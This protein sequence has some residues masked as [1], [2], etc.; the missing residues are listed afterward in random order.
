MS[1]VEDEAGD[2]ASAEPPAPGLGRSA[3]IQA[4]GTLLSRV[5]GFGRVFALAYALGETRLVDTYLLANNTPNIIYELVLGGVLSGTVL[6]VFV[7]ALRGRDEKEGWRA[8]S[9]VLTLAALA[10]AVLSFAFVVVAPLFIRLYTLR[11]GGELR[12]DQTAV[13]VDLLR[14]F[15]PQ[16]FFYGMIS[17]TSALLRARR[18]FAAPMFAPILNNVIVI[19]VF[20]AYPHLIDGR[21]LADVRGNTTA[22]VLLG[23]GTT[24]GVAAMALAQLPVRMIRRHV[25]PVWQP[26]HP[27]VRRILGL[28]GWTIGFVAANQV[29]LFVVN[30]LANGSRGHVAAYFYAYTIF[31]LPHGVA[32]V[33]IISAVQPELAD[34][35]SAE[36]R[37]GFQERLGSGLRTILAV[38]A[39]AAVGYILLAKPIVAV[40]L[41]HGALGDAGA[42]EVAG[43]LAAMA[44]GLPAFSSWLFL[45]S[46]YQAMQDTRS[47]FRLYLLENAV[48]IVAA[49]ALYPALGVQGLALAF[50]LAYTVGSLAAVADLRRRAGGLGRASLPRAVGRIGLAT[51]AMAVVVSLVAW[52]VGSNEGIG[53]VL[54]AAIG[55]GTGVTVYLLVARLA[56]V[57][58]LTSLLSI[59]RNR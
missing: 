7:Q 38:I 42:D 12:A 9:A 24:A 32:S 19:G 39:P 31:L 55:V 34:R 3:A 15:A 41:E 22:M 14:L 26:G 49:F 45:T 29:A 8:V 51:A 50:A 36:D 35:W 57:T 46:A 28:S 1:S 48:N 52:N 33:S 5:T 40:L 11:N 59:R 27:A 37:A 47:L 18:K 21:E 23:L 10:A 20:L 16:V 30:F 2:V 17:M 53:A 13:A 56:G 44:I 6:P 58:E 4:V 54:R 43:T 25:R